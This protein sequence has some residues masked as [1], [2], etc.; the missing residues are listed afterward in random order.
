MS[1]VQEH[2]IINHETGCQYMFKPYSHDV[3]VLID[4]GHGWRTYDDTQVAGNYAT[5]MARTFWN[6][7]IKQGFTTNYMGM[8]TPTTQEHTQ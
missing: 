1:G 8:G 3:K 6:S 2:C 7:L 4:D 5:H